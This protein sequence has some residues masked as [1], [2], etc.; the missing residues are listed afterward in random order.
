[1][2][3]GLLPMGDSGLC[4]HNH[5]F[6]DYFMPYETKIF[7]RRSQSK[8]SG[9]TVMPCDSTNNYPPVLLM[10]PSVFLRTLVYHNIVPER[11]GVPTTNRS[12]FH[13][14]GMTANVRPAVSRT[15]V[16]PVQ[17][18]RANDIH[19]FASGSRGDVT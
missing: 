11:K 7:E 17:W 4:Q 2:S 10:L 8:L 19:E 12:A 14:E 18:L 1:M 3:K 15:S 9:K 5:L 13:I 16:V 6:L